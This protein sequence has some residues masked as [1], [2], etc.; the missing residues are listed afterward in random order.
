ML[1]DK[2][3]VIDELK[4][5][6]EHL[7]TQYITSLER[8]RALQDENKVVRAKLEEVK[9][10]NR[11][12]K[13]KIKTLKAAKG[14]SEGEFISDAKNKINRLVREIDKCIALLNN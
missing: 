4:K 12:L 7:I 11:E 1:T 13:D 8:N 14:F 2:N 10:E 9:H 6:V 5:K 3:T